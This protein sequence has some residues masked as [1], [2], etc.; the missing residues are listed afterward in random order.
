MGQ[1]VRTVLNRINCSYACGLWKGSVEF[2]VRCSY[3]DESMIMM[4]YEKV[5]FKRAG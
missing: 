2:Q 4:I 1:D 3:P 5:L